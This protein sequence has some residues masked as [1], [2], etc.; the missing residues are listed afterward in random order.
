MLVGKELH[1]DGRGLLSLS[2]HSFAET[3]PINPLVTIVVKLAKN[4]TG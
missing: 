3:K 1:G 2:R 4:E